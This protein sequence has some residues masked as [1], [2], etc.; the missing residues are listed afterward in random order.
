MSNALP[1]VRSVAGALSRLR[2]LPAQF[3]RQASSQ[4][5][6][7][8]SRKWRVFKWTVGSVAVVAS[9]Y[10]GWKTIKR[11]TRPKFDGEKKK[12]VILGTGWG[13]LS[14]INHL[15]PD[16][17]DVTVVS[18]RNFFLFTP[19]LPSVTVGTVESRSIVEPFR[20]LMN[21]H[22]NSKNMHFL[23]AECIDV[24]SDQKRVHCKDKSGIVGEVSSFHLDY[25]ILVVAVGATT[26]T[27]RTPGVVENCHFLKEIEDAQ[28]IRNVIIDLVETASIPGQLESEQKRLLHFVVVGG[29]PTGVEFAAEVRDFLREDV[30]K[31][32]PGIS[33]HI[34]VTLVQSQDHILNNYDQQISQYTEERFKMDTINVVTNARYINPPFAMGLLSPFPTLVF[35]VGIGELN[36]YGLPVL[37]IV[38]C[39]NTPWPS[40]IL[41][42]SR[43]L[44]AAIHSW[45]AVL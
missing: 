44:L 21:K 45:L 36:T 40:N 3:I 14:V 33:D 34:Q 38:L 26:N 18:P 1:L 25:D 11:L 24:D 5:G 7:R 22:H 12:V 27:F 6:K 2:A 8:G 43:A 19:L 10:Y 13:A 9:G 4:G 37:L 28:K 15:T 39:L 23:E 41:I 32:Y 16:Q 35:I 42:H 30:A 29:G 17:F 20:K 31:I